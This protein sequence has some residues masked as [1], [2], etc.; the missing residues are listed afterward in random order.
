MYAHM[1]IYIYIYYTCM[2]DQNEEMRKEILDLKKTATIQAQVLASPAPEVLYLIGSN[3]WEESGIFAKKWKLHQGV[4]SGFLFFLYLYKV[5]SERRVCYASARSKCAIRWNPELQA[6]LIDRRGLAFD[7]E[8]SLIAYQ[9]V[10]HPGLVTTNW[11]VY[12]DDLQTWV[13]AD[14]YRI[15]CFNV[16]E[17]LTRVES[18]T[19]ICIFF[20]NKYNRPLQYER[21]DDQPTF[22]RN[23]AHERVSCTTYSAV[24]E[25]VTAI[26]TNTEI[27][28]GNNMFVDLNAI[29]APGLCLPTIHE[30]S[31][32]KQPPGLSYGG[33]DINDDPN[34][35]QRKT[36]RKVK[37]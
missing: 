6:W 9:D 16:L 15:E 30:A 24:N 13:S 5:L 17:F 11:L 2:Y 21:N 1:Y 26:G 35:L 25:N 18:N 20:Y 8:A 34:E 36:S 14:N 37:N 29:N 19:Y 27:I 12:N 22:R 10:P 23:N 3:K 4:Y 32:L 7:N 33:R 31:N 28:N